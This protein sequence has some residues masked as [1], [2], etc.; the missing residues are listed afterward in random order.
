MLRSSS[1][2]SSVLLHLNPE[3]SFA[4][5]YLMHSFRPIP[6]RAITFGKQGAHSTVHN[7]KRE[8]AKR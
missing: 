2:K 6:T 7:E 5:T 4:V 8:E 3:L 1:W